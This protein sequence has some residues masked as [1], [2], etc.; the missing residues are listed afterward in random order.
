MRAGDSCCDDERGGGVG[1]QAGFHFFSLTPARLP[2]AIR[3]D[4]RI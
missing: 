4:G 3:G 2:K 1:V